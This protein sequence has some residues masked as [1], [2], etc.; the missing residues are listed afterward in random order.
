M[1]KINL[2]PVVKDREFEV[3]VV[4][5]GRKDYKCCICNS[6]IKEGSPSVSF[7]KRVSVGLKTTFQTYRTC[8]RTTGVGNTACT[9]KKAN[10]LNVNLS[11]L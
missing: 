10:E 6:V 4:K 9:I 8:H 7:T 2:K 5:S 11:N 3:K 1:F